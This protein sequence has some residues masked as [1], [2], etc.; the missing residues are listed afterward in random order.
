MKVLSG[1]IVVASL[2]TSGSACAPSPSMGVLT[3]ESG[4]AAIYGRSVSSGI[5]LALDEARSAGVLPRGFELVSTDT[6]SAPALAAAELRRFADE[7]GVGLVVGGVTTDEALALIP[8]VD[9]E[10]VVCLSPSA[11]ASSLTGSSPYFFR[12]F[13]TDEIEGSTAARFLHDQRSVRTVVVLTDDSTFSRGLEAEFRQH[14]ELVLGGE[15]VATVH[16]E[17]EW[18]ERKAADMVNAHQPDAVYVVGHAD[19]IV[20]CLELL[21]RI[22]YEGVRATT[23]A[24]FIADLLDRGNPALEGVVFPLAALRACRDEAGGTP[25]CPFVDRYRAAFGGE[26]DLFAAHGYDAMRVAIRAL[27]DARSVDVR[28]LRRYL[29]VGLQE[30]QGVTGTIAFNERG[31][32]RRYPVMHTVFN[33][34]V[35]SCRALAEEKR[36]KL[37]ELLEGVAPSPPPAPPQPRPGLDA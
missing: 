13:A 6:R 4:P 25:E 9:K 33:G 31:D 37:R 1:A 26:P 3:P 16:D 24:V 15:I 17:L 2:L 32:V 11:S 21:S 28:E 18:W 29:R 36:R 8:V 27:V 12:L 22:G 10:R 20:T 30:F 23:S 7:L 35:V 5:R 19:H 14:F 34:R